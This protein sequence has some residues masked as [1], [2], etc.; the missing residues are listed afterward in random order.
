MGHD[1][2]AEAEMLRA[3]IAQLLR[4]NRALVAERNAVQQR[5]SQLVRLVAHCETMLGV[6]TQRLG[7]RVF[8]TKQEAARARLRVTVRETKTGTLMQTGKQR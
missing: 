7:G 1:E 3:D 4:V 2:D 6:L 5:A 8:V